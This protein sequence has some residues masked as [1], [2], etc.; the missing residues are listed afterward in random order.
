M[1]STIVMAW[2]MASPVILFVLA[3]IASSLRGS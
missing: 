2:L 3:L 1:S